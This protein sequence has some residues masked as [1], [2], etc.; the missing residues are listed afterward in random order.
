MSRFKVCQLCRKEFNTMYRIIVDNSKNHFFQK[1]G[2]K[3]H[4]FSPHI[5]F[6]DHETP[7]YWEKLLS[8]LGFEIVSIDW[9]TPNS[10]KSIGQLFFNNY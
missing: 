3:K 9:V 4:P 7:E 2:F 5:G 8:K 10:L 1:F 6:H